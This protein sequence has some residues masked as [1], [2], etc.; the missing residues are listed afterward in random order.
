M[1]K[2]LYLLLP[3][4]ISGCASLGLGDQEADVL[5][6]LVRHGERTDDAPGAQ[7]DADPGLS[8]AG[9]DRAAL[10]AEMLKDVGL[11]HVHSTDYRRTR[12]T[13]GPTLS[14]TGL[15]LS[16]Y[17]PDRLQAFAD[18]LRATAGR[19]LVV[20]HSNTTWDL[21]V[22]LG[23]SSGPPIE[24]MEYDRLYFLSPEDD[25]VRT[26]LLRFGALFRR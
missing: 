14:A 9:L 21:V 11:T 25:E 26:V 3:L 6:L 12:E 8:Q 18:E 5:V 4:L 16:L 19:H 22:A 17:D 24:A 13:A 20:G 2:L 7:R 23:G 15:E 1:K 10:L